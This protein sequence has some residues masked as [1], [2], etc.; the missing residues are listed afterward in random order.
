VR[1]ARRQPEGHAARDAYEVAGASDAQT[2]QAGLARRAGTVARRE[3][4]APAGRAARD[5][6][7]AVRRD[8]ADRGFG[9][10]LAPAERRGRTAGFAARDRH[11][12]RSGRRARGG[13]RGRHADRVV[14]GAG[15]EDL[16]YAL[17]ATLRP[18]LPA[19]VLAAGGGLAR[20]YLFSAVLATAWRRSGYGRGSEH[21]RNR[22]EHKPRESSERSSY[23]DC[24]ERRLLRVRG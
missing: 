1:A 13:R 22:E 23:P 8:G 14:C 24:S 12:R 19:Q 2:D 5:A 11:E 16:L 18:R 21:G 15:R 7:A 9:R 17:L 4:G 3:G 6:L 10:A 20:E